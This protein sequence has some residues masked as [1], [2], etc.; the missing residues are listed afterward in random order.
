MSVLKAWMEEKARHQAERDRLV[1]EI[2]RVIKGLPDNP[3][4]RRAPGNP[5]CFV[6]NFA[7]LG[8]N[9]SVEHHDFKFQY[10]EVA[11]QVAVSDDPAKRLTDLIREGKLRVNG[12]RGYTVHMHS[13]V[14]AHL[15]RVAGLPPENCPRCSAERQWDSDEG[16]QATCKDCGKNEVRQCQTTTTC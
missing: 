12:S 1:A 7:S 4:I 10:D 5:H 6:T 16:I 9:W 13:D 14:L 11:R 2:K 8:S 15:R 3:R